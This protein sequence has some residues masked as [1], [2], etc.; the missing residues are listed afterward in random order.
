MICINSINIK[1]KEKVMKQICTK[2][3]VSIPDLDIK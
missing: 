3:T 2:N 1:E